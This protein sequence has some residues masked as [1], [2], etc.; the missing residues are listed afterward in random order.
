MKKIIFLVLFICVSSILNAQTYSIPKDKFARELAKI[1]KEYGKSDIDDFIKNELTPSLLPTGD[2]TD[3]FFNKMVETCNL[4]ESKKLKPYPEIYNYIFSVYSFIKAKQPQ[5][6]F[7]AWHS[8]VDKMLDS[9]NISKFKDFIELSAGFFS[10]QRISEESNFS[11]YYKGGS[12]SFEFTDKPFMKFEGGKLMCLVENTDKKSKDKFLDSIVV[13]NAKGTYDPV[14][15]RWVGDGGTVNWTKVGLPKDKTFAVL[16]KYNASLKTSNLNVDTVVLT[17]PYF[18]KPI[19]GKF[20][21]R[22]FKINRDEDRIY[23]GFISF[24][25]RLK[26]KNIHPDVDYDGGFSLR[27]ADFVGVGAANEPAK[28]V[29]HKGG[30]PFVHLSSQLFVVNSKQIAS[31]LSSATLRLND[32]DS[33]FHPGLD[34][35]YE[36]DK[37]T[38]SLLRGKAGISQAPFLNSYHMVD[39]Y[40]PKLMWTQG[41]TDIL[42]TYDFGISQEQ[43]I[44]RLESRNFFDSKL[45]DHLQGMESVHPLVG[46]YNYTYKYDEYVITEGKAATAL[47]KTV[48][49]AK[50]TLLTLS[51]YGFISYDSEA[52]TVTVNEKLLNFIGAKSGKSDFDNL[53]FVSDL[54]PASTSKF[55]PEEIQKDPKLQEF[56]RL[57]EQ[58]NNERKAMKNFGKL[59]L[60]SMEIDLAAV[61]R[62]MI[63]QPQNTL[64]IPEKSKVVIRKNRDFDF[65]GWLNAGKLELS[66]IEAKYTYETNKISLPKTD[67][68]FF[69]VR[70]LTEKDGKESI[71]MGSAISGMIG[72]ILVDAPNNRSGGSKDPKLQVFPIIK[73]TNSPKV[74]YNDPSIYRG[75]YDSTRF[76]FT[77]DPFEMDSLDNFKEKG[78][79][80]NGELTSAGIFPKFREKLVIMPDY[81]FGFSTK[82][83]EKGYDFYSTKSK[84]ENK[85]VLSNNGLQGAGKIEFIES[86]SESNA[87]TFLPDSTV[88]LAKFTNKPVEVGV[89]FPDVFSEKAYITYVPKKQILKVASTQGVPLNFFKEEAKLNGMA[90][91]SATGMTGKGI[92]NL[93]EANLQ[94]QHYKFKRWDADADTTTFNLKNKYQEPDE[95]P[96]SFKTDN[97]QS[98]VS[99]KDRKGIFKSNSGESTVIFPVNQYMCKMD[100]MTW[101]MDQE[102]LEMSESQKATNDLTIDSDLDLAVNNFFSIHPKQDSL[103]FRAPKAKF[104]MKEKT[105]YCN[106]TEFIDV[107]D[108]RIFPDEKKV[109][110]RKKAVMEPLNNSRIVANYITKFHHFEKANTVISARLSYIS[111]GI[112]P[113]YDAD[114]MKTMITIDKIYVDSSYQTVALGK[115]PTDMNFKLSK[116]FDYYGDIRIN[117]ASPLISFAGA[118][119]I[120][121]SCDKFPK[122]WMSFKSQIDPKNI[123]IPVSESMKTLEGIPI[124]AGIVWRDSRDV[125]SVKL[126]PTFLSSLANPKDPIVITAA[127]FLQYDFTAKEYQIASREKLNNRNE[128]GNFI[129][130]HTE[131]CSLNGDGKINLG[132]DYGTVTVDAV[133]IVNYNQNN[134][135]TSMNIT[136]RYNVPIDKNSWEAV[137]DKIKATE[138]LKPL[139][140]NSTTLEQA[141]VEWTDRKTADKFKEEFTTKGTVRK[142]PN[143]LE[144]ALIIT[145][146][147]LESFDSKDVVQ[148]GIISNADDAVLVNFFD[149]SILKYLPTKAFFQQVYSEN[150]TGDK[151]NVYIS[152]PGGKEYFWDYAMNKK[153]GEL[154][155]ITT[156]GDYENTINGIKDDKKKGKNFRYEVSSNRVLL[157][158][159][160][161]LFGGE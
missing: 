120:N 52:K 69:R 10:E 141:L 149:K 77:L 55:T 39:M 14:I 122:S 100:V 58:K 112:Y 159:F 124:S 129:A 138:G 1:M 104:S 47:G 16:K 130:L 2:F 79:F 71:V 15:K 25:K 65:S 42:L 131:S 54:R 78:L 144:T 4:M 93:P 147:Q 154:K 70:P 11:W 67:I 43:K 28:M 157:G 86:L 56:V 114:S 87:F 40:V 118:T 132:M 115:I 98:H 22:A 38:L 32:K 9:R 96:L 64:V 17:I 8:S 109:V 125:D 6:S 45:Y 44:A 72:E 90:V 116:Q 126:Y 73:V 105:I 3:A 161:R 36:I 37:K 18:T 94:S 89:Q 91:V 110:I 49:Q 82:A 48:E 146:L 80:L 76:Y 140:F 20:T 160:M 150:V 41:E 24:E 134:G 50:S 57:T 61:D 148:K 133:G 26:I 5:T 106:N 152:A 19:E 139:D 123:Q 136:A 85:I 113:Y 35:L 27:G 34:V 66:T 153:E 101:F 60:S 102:A 29:I 137:A 142:L 121:H 51:S 46:L 143:E 62:V 155:I 128:K 23:P 95:D 99:F 33:I 88:G 103:Q 151:F 63:S 31:N 68:G 111:N 83:P 97:V 127:G 135:K 74:Y 117:A 30:K 12:Y 21:E 145:G 7:N 13:L 59:S 84:Y 158:F 119:R 156:D 81:S 75:A 107:A 108:A 53:S 92:I